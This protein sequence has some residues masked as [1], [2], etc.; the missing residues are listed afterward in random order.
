MKTAQKIYCRIFQ[1]CFH[2]A[3]PILPYRRPKML[4]TPADMAKVLKEKKVTSVLLVTDAN[5]RKMGLTANTEET[6]KNS[7][8]SVTVFDKTHPNPTT[9]DVEEARQLYL[10]NQCSAI[11]GFGG[12]SAMDC[13][14]ATGARIAC[15]KK[16][17]GKMEGILRVRRGIP[18][19]IAVPTTAGTGSETTLAAVIVDSQTRHK[20]P[21]NDFALIPPYAMLDKTLT[22]SLPPMLTATTGLDALTHAV[23]AYIGKSTIASTRKDAEDAVTLIFRYLPTAVKNGSDTEAREKML[24]AAYLAGNAFTRS[25]VG[26]V[27]AVAHSLGGQYNTPHGLAN[28]VLLAPVLRYYGACINEKL[29]RLAVCAG[30]A[31][32]SDSAE[33]ASEAFISAIEQ[34]QADF[35]IP[36]TIAAL[37]AADIPA[38]AKQAAH[39]GNPLYPVPVEM[40]ADELQALYRLIL[41]E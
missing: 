8:I 20:Y 32:E 5:I 18:T 31:K 21:I 19:L 16:P 28:A 13:A 23:E 1:Q 41:E 39:E 30:I 36:R 35:G 17:L 33:K 29:K 40:D 24:E 37:K 11:I 4:K 26:Y 27:H 25:Y 9:D 7:G 38:L 15:P 22:L 2:I 3:L 6:L 34:M 10:S 12:G 14:K